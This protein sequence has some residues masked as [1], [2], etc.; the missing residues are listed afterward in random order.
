MVRFLFTESIEGRGVFSRR[1]PTERLSAGIFLALIALFSGCEKSSPVSREHNKGAESEQ[2]RNAE[3]A[4]SAQP[5]TVTE[6]PRSDAAPNDA[7]EVDETPKSDVAAKSGIARDDAPARPGAIAAQDSTAV[8]GSSSTTGPS[9]ATPSA[10]SAGRPP[11]HTFAPLGATAA[12]ALAC[13]SDADCVVSCYKD[14]RCCEELCGCSRVYH[15]TFAA[16]LAAAVKANCSP[17]VV[18]P[19]ARCVGTKSAKAACDGGK[20]VLAQAK[21]E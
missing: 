3:E 5:K 16:R 14:G 9:N 12:S 7:P 13:E 20:C 21:N 10:A 17:D 4:S 18:C 8:P 15:R 19:V 11:A 2:T 1:R 6:T